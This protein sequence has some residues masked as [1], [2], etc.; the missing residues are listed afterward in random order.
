M[1]VIESKKEYGSTEY[2]LTPLNFGKITKN[3]EYLLNYPKY[4]HGQPFLNLAPFFQKALNDLILRLHDCQ[5]SP[6]AYWLKEDTN[7][8]IV[9]LDILK[10]NI[11]WN[12]ENTITR[13][14]RNLMKTHIDKKSKDIF[15]LLHAADLIS[16]H[17]GWYCRFLS[18]A[19]PKEHYECTSPHEK[20]RIHLSLDKQ[21]KT[22]WTNNYGARIWKG[23]I[24]NGLKIEV[25]FDGEFWTIDENQTFYAISHRCPE[26]RGLK[27]FT[28]TLF[29][30][31]QEITQM[32]AKWCPLDCTVIPNEM[33]ENINEGH[34]YY[35]YYSLPHN[36]SIPQS[37][38]KE[39][40][41]FDDQNYTQVKDFS[42]KAQKIINQLK[43]KNSA[44]L[45]TQ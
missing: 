21:D 38:F 42:T 22:Y 7:P 8:L 10:K 6:L 17:S 37:W 4:L 14:Y 12:S 3:N 29:Y 34:I 43:K 20:L 24:P 5:D 16:F 33:A 1:E 41:G 23:I 15:W 13:S 36:A 44:K 19:N 45:Y 40:K 35:S 18:M 32:S 31:D 27:D 26:S 28:N 2:Q 11:E 25:C 30:Q 9:A 39:F